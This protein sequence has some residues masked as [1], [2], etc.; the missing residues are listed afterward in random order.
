MLR[1][2]TALQLLSPSDVQASSMAY[3]SHRVPLLFEPLLMSRQQAQPVRVQQ[4]VHQEMSNAGKSATSRVAEA[5]QLLSPSDGQRASPRVPLLFQD[6]PVPGVLQQPG[7][8]RQR[9]SSE[10]PE[11][12]DQPSSDCWGELTRCCMQT[13][14]RTAQDALS[15]HSA[16][17]RTLHSYRLPAHWTRQCLSSESLDQPSSNCSGELK[18]SCT[19]RSQEGVPASLSELLLSLHRD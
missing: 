12:L 5:L 6:A 4:E 2:A 17:C 13:L 8:L 3:T 7:D 11:L 1:V 15:T 19:L 18:L 16:R 14:C 9:A 10:M